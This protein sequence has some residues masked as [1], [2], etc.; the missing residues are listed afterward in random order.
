MHTVQRDPAFCCFQIA[1]LCVTLPMAAPEPQGKQNHYEGDEES[2]SDASDERC[3]RRRGFLSRDGVAVGDSDS[4][5]SGISPLCGQNDIE[6]S[7]RS[8]I[9]LFTG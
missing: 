3:D 9:T 2:A 6:V 1:F 7:C 8:L 5:L 4:I